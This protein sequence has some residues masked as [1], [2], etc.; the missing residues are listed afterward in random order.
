M[1]FTDKRGQS[2]TVNLDHVV[3]VLHDGDTH[4]LTLS[5][6][7]EIAVGAEAVPMLVVSG[8]PRKIGYQIAMGMFGV[9]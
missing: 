4:L 9:N 1:K 8:D 2:W 6:G 3:S 5:S 7:Q